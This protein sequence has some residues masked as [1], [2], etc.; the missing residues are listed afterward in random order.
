MRPFLGLLGILI[1]AIGSEFND[2]VTSIALG[3]VTGGLGLSHDPGTWF[4][5]LYVSAEVIGMALSP[6]LLVTFRLR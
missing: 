4:E 5:S 1:A 2:Q 6:W 3:D